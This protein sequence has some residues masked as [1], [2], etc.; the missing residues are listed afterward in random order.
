MK[1]GLLVTINSDDPA[2]FGGYVNENYLALAE[3]L[4]LT[5]EDISQLAKNSFLASFL[6]KDE[7]EIMIKIIEEYNISFHSK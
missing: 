5:T 4:A 1:S 3:S 2:Y 7:K 6:D